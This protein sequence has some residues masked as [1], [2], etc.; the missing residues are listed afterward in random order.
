MKEYTRVDPGTGRVKPLE[1][2]DWPDN[3]GQMTLP[4]TDKGVSIKFNARRLALVT[5]ALEQASVNYERE[6]NYTRSIDD[7]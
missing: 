1:D 5:L 2:R 7:C 6:G 3:G 4:L